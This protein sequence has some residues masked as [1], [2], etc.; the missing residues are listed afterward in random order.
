MSWSKITVQ[1]EAVARGAI[2]R[3]V[4]DFEEVMPL[5]DVSRECALF[6]RDA[7]NATLIFIS[8][9]FGTIAPQLLS[10]YA[11]V[12]CEAPPPRRDDEE[13]GTS[14][15]LAAHESSAWSLLN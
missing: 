11:A 6:A 12:A 13:F 9:K 5:D 8:P 15:L 3:V 2:G 7:T 10:K 4:E 1:D 14:L